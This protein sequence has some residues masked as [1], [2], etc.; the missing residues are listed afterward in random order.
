MAVSPTDIGN[1]DYLL[2]LLFEANICRVRTVGS[3][4]NA[5]RGIPGSSAQVPQDK[6][7]EG[8]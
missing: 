5:D 1:A 7:A 6:Q 4:G 2:Y 3:V 8:E